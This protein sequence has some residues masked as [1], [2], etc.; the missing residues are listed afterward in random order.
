MPVRLPPLAAVNTNEKAASAWL[1]PSLSMLM[2]YTASGCISELIRNGGVAL[3]PV[4]K[5]F[6]S[7]INTVLPVSPDAWKAY[8]SVR[9]RRASLPGNLR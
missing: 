2:R 8:R 4:V 1:S 9:S 3:M 7:M 5:G 6:T